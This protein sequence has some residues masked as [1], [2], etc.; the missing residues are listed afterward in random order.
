MNAKVADSL[1]TQLREEL[2]SSYLYLSMAA[3]FENEGLRG[4]AH[5]MEQQAK[6]ELEHAMKI[7]R[8][9][10]DRGARIK[11]LDIEQPKHEWKSPLDAFEDALKHEQYITSR[12]NTL[13]TVA[14]EEGDYATEIFLQWF[15]TEQVEEEANVGEIVDR[16][17]MVQNSPNGLFMVDREL[18]MRK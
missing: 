11:L 18:A 8:F 17:R 2:F 12:I 1:N 14:R 10:A 7:Y 9:I 13:M 3:Y 5:W 6:E 15:I 4:F 16:L